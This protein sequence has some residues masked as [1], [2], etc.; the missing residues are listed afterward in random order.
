MELIAKNTKFLEGELTPP[1]SK[2]QGIRAVLLSVLANG[3]STLYNLPTSKDVETAITVCQQLGAFVQRNQHCTYIISKGV[4]LCSEIDFVDSDNSGITTRFVMPMLGLRQSGNQP[5]QLDCDEQMRQRPIAPLVQ[6]LQTLGLTID[7]LKKPGQLP[8]SV[9]GELKG[10][11]AT[12]DGLT[13]QYLSALL[14]SLPSAQQDSVIRVTDLHERPYVEMTL[15]WLKKN[16]IKFAHEHIAN[17]DI[18]RIPGNQRWSAQNKHIAVDFSSASYLLAAAVLIPGTVTLHGIDMTDPQGDKQLVTLLQSMG[19]NISIDEQKRSLTIQGG[20]P[21]QWITIDGNDIPDL[22]PTLAVIGTQSTGCTRIYNVK[23]ARIKET[24]RIHSMV[25]GLTKMGANVEEGEDHLTI[26]QS[27]LVGATKLNGYGD[28]R[29]VMALALAGL[30]AQ[31]ETTIT[32]AKAINKTFPQ[33]V[34]MMQA[35]GANMEVK[36]S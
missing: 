26:H 32:D 6:A 1:G 7:Y 29:T 3:K 31:G 25:E 21:L 18:F 28:H 27:A 20:N 19:A 15:D 34:E 22:L 12:V 5:V 23:H 16:N 11:A 35:L 30:L 13:S 24:D 9:R 4:P 33:Y 2:S 17:E 8:I 36:E 14:L 10:G